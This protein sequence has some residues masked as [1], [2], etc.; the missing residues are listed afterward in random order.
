MTPA[1]YGDS[2]IRYH[3][4]LGVQSLVEVKVGPF[5]V[6]FFRKGRS[7]SNIDSLNKP[8]DFDFLEGIILSILGAPHTEILYICLDGKASHSA[9][10]TI[11]IND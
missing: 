6:H 8:I 1:Y 10:A 2:I 4:R 9:A 3:D 7:V 5:Y 11:R